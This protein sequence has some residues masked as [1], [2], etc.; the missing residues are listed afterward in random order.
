M[1]LLVSKVEVWAGDLPDQAG[2]L[3]RVLEALVDGGADLECVIGRRRPEEPGSG[4]V[5]VTPIKSKKAQTAAQSVGLARTDIATL[6]IEGP[7]KPGLGARMMRAVAEGGV[8]VRGISALV[9]GNKFVA[10]MGFDNPAD[11]AAAMKAL[12]T[13]NGA[14]KPARRR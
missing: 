12:K 11:L 9:L 1:A 14:K 7:D 3:A 4:E 10:Y 5:F 8:N 2:G 6:R 13:V